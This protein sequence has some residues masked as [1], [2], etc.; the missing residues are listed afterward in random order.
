MG[1]FDHAED[2]DRRPERAPW[3]A[4]PD[5]V[6][7]A[8]LKALEKEPEYIAAKGGDWEAAITLVSRLVTEATI[9]QVRGLCEAAAE[10]RIVPVLAE[11]AE[12][13]NKI[14]LAFAEV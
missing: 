3:G 13:R 1:T 7:N 11:E 10:L 4:F 5:L 14:P 8:D 2:R 9:E 6:R 12:G